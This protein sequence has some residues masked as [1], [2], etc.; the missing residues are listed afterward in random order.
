MEKHSSNMSG[1]KEG[2]GEMLALDE[3]RG[4]GR[5]RHRIIKI[6]IMEINRTGE[7]GL[8]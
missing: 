8:G 2:V 4:G 3:G 6:K 5:W 1:R 7:L